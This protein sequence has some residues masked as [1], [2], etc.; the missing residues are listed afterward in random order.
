[1]K[2]SIPELVRLLNYYTKL[3]DEGHPAISDKEWDEMYFE[4][5]EAEKEAGYALPDSPTQKIT[6]SVVTAL[7]KVD[8]NHKMLSLAKTK[9]F[10][11]VQGFLGKDEYFLAMCKMDGLTCSLHYSN[12]R[13]VSA[14][15]RGNGYTGENILHNAQVIPSIPKHINYYDELIVDGE[16]ICTYENFKKFDQEYSNPR[17]FA[18]GSIRLLDSTECA[19]RGL[20]FV[21]WDIIKGLDYH[22]SH[23]DPKTGIRTERIFYTTEQKNY[24]LSQKINDLRKLGFTTVPFILT[25]DSRLQS[26]A[27]LSSVL[28][29][30]AKDF[31]YPIDGLVFK[32][33]NISY[34]AKLGETAH[35]FKNAIAYKFYDEEYETRLVN[36]EWQVGRKGQL[37]PVAIFKPVQCDDAELT[38]ASLHNLSMMKETLGQYPYADQPIWVAR[39]NM[40][41]PQITRAEK[42]EEV[43][44]HAIF[45]PPASCPVCGE[46]LSVSVN[47]TVETLLC[48]NEKCTGSLLQRLDHFCSKKG[49]DI[50]GLSESTLEKLMDWDWVTCIKDIFKLNT[51][52]LE[53]INKE[54]FGEKS[55]QKILSAIDQAR[56]CELWQFISALGIPF[57]GMNVAK[58][59]CKHIENWED[60]INKINNNYDFSVIPTFGDAKVKAILSFDYSEAKDVVKNYIVFKENAPLENTVSD[61][62]QGKVFCI[63]GK[64]QGYANRNLLKAEIESYGG[65]VVD[66]VN[67]KVNYLINNNINST[68]AKNKKAKELGIPII[69]ESEYKNLLVE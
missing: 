5:L 11:E 16:I 29:I 33:N 4:L 61:T 2:K 37:T 30:A 28:V 43:G 55:V 57:I 40:I 7:E 65:Q 68:S 8:H 31:S 19:K 50:K 41:I 14:E 54:G 49:L 58:E 34:G 63:T 67:S 44:G 69:T 13:L 38:R 60:F 56:T 52:R 6:Y 35:H 22:I 48:T 10:E 12:G 46:T 24:L 36:I 3:Y 1:M 62:L 26:L 45:V 20:K 23:K 17:N 18:A 66:G 9:E 53:W 39:M 21:V 64:L 32:F 25:D 51:H 47:N 59:L 27:D 15:T 42:I